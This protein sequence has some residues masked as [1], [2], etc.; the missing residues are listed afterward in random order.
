MT[1][2][3]ISLSPKFGGFSLM[4][5]TVYLYSSLAWGMEEANLNDQPLSPS[6]KRKCSSPIPTESPSKRQKKS[7]TDSLSWPYC[8]RSTSSENLL[9][10]ELDI[11]SPTIKAEEE[12]NLPYNVIKDMN[13][14]RDPGVPQ[15]LSQDSMACIFFLPSGKAAKN[16]VSPVPNTD[17]TQPM[18]LPPFSTILNSLP[19]FKYEGI[20]TS[21]CQSSP[22]CAMFAP[23]LVIFH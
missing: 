16:P 12:K 13:M 17:L 8:T 6:L 22:P 10:E 18:V 2:Y 5:L 23:H 1:L 11:H 14:V 7:N 21:Y 4:M 15:P 3:S 9:N 19:P 20:K